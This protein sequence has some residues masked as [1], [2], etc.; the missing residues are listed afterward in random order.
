MQYRSLKS[1]A[2][3]SGRQQRSRTGDELSR[4]MR[5]AGRETQNRCTTK[6]INCAG[7]EFDLIGG[8]G[9]REGWV[10][11]HPSNLEYPFLEL[12]RGELTVCG[13]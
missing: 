12:L 5:I 11:R 13:V 8:D 3:L 4:T 9:L 6:F 2:Q 7:S 1:F 10:A